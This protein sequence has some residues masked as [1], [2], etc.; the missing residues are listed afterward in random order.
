M[1]LTNYKFCKEALEKY[2]GLGKCSLDDFLRHMYNLEKNMGHLSFKEE[3]NRCQVI[4][5]SGKRKGE[6]C[7]RGN[8]NY[9][10]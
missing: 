1:A 6:V 4:L 5:K 3:T 2:P 7:G 8:C 9:H 10:K